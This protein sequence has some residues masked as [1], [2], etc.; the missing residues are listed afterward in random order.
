M[1]N[2]FPELNHSLQE[3]GEPHAIQD[4]NKKSQVWESG[5]LEDSPRLL[6][7]FMEIVK[8][9]WEGR[10][11]TAELQRR[12][13]GDLFELPTSPAKSCRVAAFVS[14]HLCSVGLLVVHLYYQTPQ[15]MQATLPDTLVKNPN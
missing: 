2:G 1:C 13:F 7:T 11:Q 12:D 6:H 4:V 10:P 3:A 5:Y 14:H 9:D 8:S 15:V